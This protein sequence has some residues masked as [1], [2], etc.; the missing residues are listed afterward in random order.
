M[1][2]IS[3]ILKAKILARTSAPLHAASTGSH[4]AAEE[5]APVCGFGR[6]RKRRIASAS[7]AVMLFTA[8]SY[9]RFIGLAA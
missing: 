5:N 2:Q 9:A 7:G 8:N 4:K 1:I 6:Q 3:A